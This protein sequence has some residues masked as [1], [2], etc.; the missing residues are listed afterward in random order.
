VNTTFLGIDVGTSGIRACLI[1]AAGQELATV[2]TALPEPTRTNACIEQE[3][4]LWWQTLQAVLDELHSLHTL[5]RLAALSIDGTSATLLA[6]DNQGQPLGPALMYN[7]HRAQAEAAIIAAAAPLNSGAQGAHSSLAKALWLLRQPMSDKPR[8]L[9]HQ[10]DWLAAR[11]TGQYGISD[12]NNALKLG[13]DPITRTW[14]SWI[15]ALKLD[16]PLL[17]RVVAPGTRLGSVLP[18]WAQR[19][20]MPHAQVVAGTTDSTAAFLATG[21][22]TI[23]QAVTSLGSTLV[24]KVLAE[25][26]IFA[27]EYGVY[28]HR[29]GERW[30]VGGASNSGGAVLRH[31]FSSDQLGRLE[32]HIDPT[33][34]T[35]LDYYPLP[36]IGER[37]PVNDPQLQ[38]RMTP[39]P[40]ED[41][42]FLQGL[43]E[44]IAR[45]EQRGYRLLQALGAPYP[46][47]VISS[48]GGANNAAWRQLRER[49]L[50]VPVT[51]ATHQDAAYGAALLARQSNA[52]GL[53]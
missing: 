6:C 40:S 20:T 14:P 39:R 52:D 15:N 10:A 3:P 45:I 34:A 44:G 48:G 28:S 30:L 8:Y 26:P 22:Q 1:D 41:A 12:E 19:W 23:G 29:L 50:A 43:L 13:Y 37:F 31:Y 21:A 5:N 46:T 36:G 33:R 17:P 7:D 49:L 24:L 53:F 47:E 18:E 42:V 9:L 38:P 4:D 11:L 32:P 35:G 25:R 16:E 27:P 2:H 51:L